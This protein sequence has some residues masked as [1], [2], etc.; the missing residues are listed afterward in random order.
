MTEYQL[1]SKKYCG[2]GQTDGM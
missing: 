2:F 1:F